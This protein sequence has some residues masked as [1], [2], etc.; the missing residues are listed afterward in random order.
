MQSVPDDAFT[1]GMLTVACHVTVLSLYSWLAPIIMKW[2]VSTRMG[3]F[4][5]HVGSTRAA[6]GAALL[7]MGFSCTLGLFLL[8]PPQ[9]ALS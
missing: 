6:D 1:H 7:Q 9:I 5:R 8:W 2:T 3:T 4:E